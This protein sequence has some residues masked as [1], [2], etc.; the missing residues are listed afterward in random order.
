MVIETVVYTGGVPVREAELFKASVHYEG[1]NDG[2][3]LKAG[4][5]ISDLG[6]LAVTALTEDYGV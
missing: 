3:G 4:E 5:I 2:D 6:K 1:L